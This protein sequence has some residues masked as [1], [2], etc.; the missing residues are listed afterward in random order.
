MGWGSLERGV[1]GHET[2]VW[3]VTMARADMVMHMHSPWWR[4]RGAVTL[5]VHRE[6]DGPDVVALEVPS[7]PEMISA[8]MDCESWL[9]V[10]AL[11]RRTT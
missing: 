2:L 3:C 4:P 7:E 5:W 9:E 11:L 6:V 10:A 8:V 1:I